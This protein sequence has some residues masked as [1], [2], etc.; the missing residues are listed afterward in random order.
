M[1]FTYRKTMPKKLE[2]SKEEINKLMLKEHYD[3]PE[4]LEKSVQEKVVVVDHIP[5]YR[6]VVFI[7]QRDPG[8]MM[9][10]HYRT[11]TH[12]M[13]HYDLMH[14]EEYD[15]PVEVIEHVENCGYPMY[16]KEQIVKGIQVR[17][18]IGYKYHFAFRSPKAYKERM[19]A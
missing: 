14:G 4:F 10:F 16:G 8:V 11:K 19:V 6:K 13:K 3:E 18:I 17:P 1:R 15:L 12:P 5:Q 7:N 2:K 9:S